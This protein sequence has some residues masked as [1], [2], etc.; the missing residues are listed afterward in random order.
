MQNVDCLRF[1]FSACDLTLLPG[2]GE[3]GVLAAPLNPTFP[4]QPIDYFCENPTYTLVG[5]QANRC[6]GFGGYLQPGPTC[7]PTA[8]ML[9]QNV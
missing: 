9:L 2:V 7:E 5:L 1:Y 8:G 3:N 4:F 6:D